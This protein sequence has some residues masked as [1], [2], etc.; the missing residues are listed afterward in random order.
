ML[1]WS[2]LPRA[3]MTEGSWDA[4]TVAVRRALGPM[5]VGGALMSLLDSGGNGQSNR[6]SS[7]P[8]FLLG[9]LSELEL[10]A[11]IGAGIVCIGA[12]A[13]F[14]A[15]LA[16]GWIRLHQAVLVQ[17]EGTWSI[18]GSGGDRAASML[19]WRVLRGTA[20]FVP[21][22]LPI[23]PMVVLFALDPTWIDGD[24]AGPGLA[25][26]MLGGIA[27]VAQWLWIAPGVILG[28]YFVVLEGDDPIR[29]LRRSVDAARGQ[30]GSL[31]VLFVVLALYQALYALLGLLMLCVGVLVTVP[32]ARAAADNAWCRAFLLAR[33]GIDAEADWGSVGVGDHGL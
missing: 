17:G 33:D 20:L 13:L 28:P 21:F 6:S 12:A 18:L 26:A 1:R 23:A 4:A 11:L 16:P 19:G 22:T 10:V 5:W 27:A 29:A 25:V 14:R 3:L 24:L 15:W 7:D 30:R 8:D 2:T 31:I 9:G 32:L